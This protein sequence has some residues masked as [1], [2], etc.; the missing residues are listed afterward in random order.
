M[1]GKLLPLNVGD[2]GAEEPC[3]MNWADMIALTL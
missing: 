1:S 3:I 2:G